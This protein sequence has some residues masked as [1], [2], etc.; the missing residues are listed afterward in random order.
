MGRG[1]GGYRDASNSEKRLASNIRHLTRRGFPLDA[2]GRFGKATSQTASEIVT[3]TPFDTAWDFF[4]ELG[5]GGSLVERNTK[6]GLVIIRQFENGSSISFRKI[7]TS[8]I[9]LQED[10]P[11]VNVNLKGQPSG[12]PTPYTVHFRRER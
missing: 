3:S 2:N 10:N 7:T 8:S 4:T 6:N 12:S 1:R 5:A 9:R 11:A